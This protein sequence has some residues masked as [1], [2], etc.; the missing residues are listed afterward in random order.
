MERQLRAVVYSRVSTDAQERDGTSLDTQERASQEYVADNGWIPIESIRDTAS[1]YSLDRPGIEKVRMMLRQGMVD[2]VVAYAV[3]RLSRNQNHIGVL[4]DEIEQA[5]AKLQF[6]TE[7]LEDTATGKFILTVRA[8]IGEVER[9]KITERSMRGK[10][11]RAKSGKIPQGTG[12]GCYGYRYNQATGNREINEYQAIVVRRMFQRYLETRSFSAV[13]RELNEA[14]IPS[15]GGGR[16]Y[17]I[18]IRRQL[19]N[20]CYTGRFIYRKTKRVKVRK[21]NGN[22]FTRKQVTRPTEEWIVVSEACPRIIDEDT[23]Q[24]VQ[25]IINDPERTKHLP[26]PQVYMLRGRAKCGICSSA[27][28]GQTLKVKG[29]AYG[30]YRCRHV[31]DKNTSRTCTARYVRGD[32]LETAV[33]AEVERVLS[34]PAIVLKELENQSSDSVD[35]TRISGVEGA[36]KALAAREERLVKLYGLGSVNEQVIQ[37]QLEEISRER[38]GLVQQLSTLQRPVGYDTRLVDKDSLER[39]CSRV[40]Q[41]LGKADDSEKIMALEALQ[42][43][44]EATTTTATVTGIL[45]LEAPEFIKSEQSCRC[46]FNG[47]KPPTAQLDL[48]KT[49]SS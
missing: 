7:R 48:E 8:F 40:A 43:S 34:S 13:S 10:T 1:G 9:E 11:E 25:D 32:K 35:I 41:W 33:W 14:G 31:Y 21:S 37:G 27:M 5:G 49:R 6:V 15:L 12:K 45:P 26:T 44:V 30:Y 16:W 19:L 47:D 42:V 28:V 38:I 2:V 46:L 24:R 17:P 22:G 3:D 36:I 4:F 39:V 23:W 29:R 18:T 20:E